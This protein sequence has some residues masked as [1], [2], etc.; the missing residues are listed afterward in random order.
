M[1]DITIRDATINDADELLSIYDYYVR[2]TAITFEITTPSLDE[3][4]DRM[5]DVM[6]HYP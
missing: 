1:S 3:F 5:K 2:N 6:Q 4:R